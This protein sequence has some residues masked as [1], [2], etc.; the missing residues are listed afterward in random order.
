MSNEIVKVSEGGVMRYS[1][2]PTNQVA[3][4]REA[5]ES[6]MVNL[7]SDY[8]LFEEIKKQYAVIHA[9]L[10]YPLPGLTD[11][12]YTCNALVTKL[13]RE[14]KNIRKNEIAIAFNNGIHNKYGNKWFGLSTISLFFF[15]CE[16]CIEAERTEA[17]RIRNLPKQDKKPPTKEEIFNIAK[18]NAL[19]AY[20]L[21]L[22]EKEFERLTS[23]VYDFLFSIGILIIT[24]DQIKDYFLKANEIYF[25]ELQAKKN[26][27]TDPVKN[28]ELANKIDEFIDIIATEDKTLTEKQNIKTAGIVKR[29]AVI[30]LFQKL[31]F[32]E[33]TMDALEKA[34]DKRNR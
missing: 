8:D 25:N 28:K 6:Q 33:I 24:D 5:L 4:I 16:Y 22:D 12:T 17:L 31:S 10:K 11:I 13:R 15:V 32:Q 29:L 7:M 1:E 3:I 23:P 20:R 2:S 18:G 19:D 9:D 30:N 14:P 27:N 26:A 34:I 21:F